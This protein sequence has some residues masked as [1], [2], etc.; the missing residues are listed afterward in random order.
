MVGVAITAVAAAGRCD[1]W[2]GFATGAA[3]GIEAGT[4]GCDVVGR[5]VVERA[6]GWATCTGAAEGLAGIA[7]VVVEAA[8]N[9]FG[10]D[11]FSGASAV[12]VVGPAA[13]R[14]AVP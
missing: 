7:C 14:V 11:F 1:G 9:P 5:G 10:A 3:D 13:R 12:V 6:A 2:A 8:E 4:A